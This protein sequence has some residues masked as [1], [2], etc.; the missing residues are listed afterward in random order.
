MKVLKYINFFVFLC[1]IFFAVFL[2]GLSSKYLDII[3]KNFNIAVAVSAED[4]PDVV[5]DRIISF[6]EV[7]DVRIIT[8]LEIFEEFKKDKIYSNRIKLDENPFS[9]YLLVYLETLNL[10]VSGVAGKITKVQGVGDVVYDE[11]TLNVHYNLD[12][13]RFVING[14]II[15]LIAYTLIFA[16]IR[17]YKKNI[18]IFKL[19]NFIPKIFVYFA[20]SVFCLAFVGVLFRHFQVE[21]NYFLILVSVIFSVLACVIYED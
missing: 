5:A 18:I 15:F 20:T 8:P 12:K 14:F 19:E 17:T 4:K 2:R 6:D 21:Y 10:D 1:I 9:G 7:S 13:L 11:T 16:F 3:E